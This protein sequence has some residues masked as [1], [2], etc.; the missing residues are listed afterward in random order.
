MSINDYI[1]GLRD[2]FIQ[3]RND[4]SDFAEQ[5]DDTRADLIEWIKEQVIK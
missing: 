4:D 3:L 2:E 1:K 5:Y